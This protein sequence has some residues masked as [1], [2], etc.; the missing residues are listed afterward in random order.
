MNCAPQHWYSCKSDVM[1]LKNS[2]RSEGRFYERGKGKAVKA[3]AH[4]V[5]EYVSSSQHNHIDQS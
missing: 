1:H 4:D 5:C 2:L 3:S